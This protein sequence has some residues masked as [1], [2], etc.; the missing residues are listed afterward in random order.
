MMTHEDQR[1]QCKHCTVPV[2]SGDTCA[3]CATYT[4][5]AGLSAVSPLLAGAATQ[6]Q[7]AAEDAGDALSA[8]SNDAPLTVAVDLVTAIAHMKAARRLLDKTSDRLA[9]DAAEVAR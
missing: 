8:L 1:T 3:F 9:A 7:Q 5:P 4:P 2:D 6:A